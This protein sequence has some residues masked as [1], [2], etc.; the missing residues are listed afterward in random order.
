MIYR[1]HFAH[2]GVAAAFLAAPAFAQPPTPARLAAL[3]DSVAPAAVAAA[4]VPGVVVAVVRGDS[5]LLLRGYGLARL[6][7]SIPADPER[8]IYRLAS[9]AK[10]F[11]ATTVLQR[12]ALGKL[13]LERDIQEYVPNVP[14]PRTFDTP[15][16]LRHLL[17][18][19]G[20][21]DERATGYAARTRGDMRPLGEY[22]AAR[23]PDRGWAPGAVVG[24][25]NH[26]MALAGYVAEREAGDAFAALAAR[27]VFVPMGMR[28]TYY[29]E[30]PD[31]ALGDRLAPGYRCGP[32]GCDRAPVVWSHAYPV[33]LAFSTAH[34]MSRFMR[35]WLNDGALDGT[36]VL[37]PSVVSRG[38]TRQFAHDAR[39]PGMGFG[40]FEQQY[41]GHRVFAHSGG[42]PGTAT[43]LVLA[44]AERLGVFVATNA[45]EP[46]VT[47]MIVESLLDA[48]LTDRTPPP[49]VATGPVREYA[50]TYRLTRYAHHTVERFPGVFAFSVSARAEG[51]T[52]IMPA[53]T[54]ER[55]FV[56]VD[57]LLLREVTD[58]TMMAL[59]RD[60]RGAV[61]HLF[62]GLP[63]GGAELPG[64][65]ERAPWYE[66]TH[67]LNEYASALVGLPPL[68]LLAW[69]LVA[70]SRRLWRRRRGAEARRVPR[71]AIAAIVVAVAGCVLFLG[72]GLGFIAVGTRDLARSQGMA[73]GMTTADVALL[74]LAW[75][76]AAASLAVPAF[77]AISW[78]QRWWTLFGRLSYSALALLA[79]ATVHFLVWWQYIP[80]RW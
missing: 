60:G 38:M 5:V 42:V 30:P 12:V 22:L 19:T 18:H 70:I 73:F 43:T 37:D 80:G 13:D 39:V 61:S 1:A 4:H 53:G 75:V 45:G 35:A 24:Y 63:S 78:R 58:G 3:V 50:G 8:S 31:V 54:R 11:V 21:F 14:I 17:T 15:I 66:G 56:R 47:R 57:S 74:R 10:L 79:V 27:S 16:T 25:S 32:S 64:A 26:G 9:V 59:R 77:A 33:G 6:E 68:V 36:T 29:I 76:A 2:I 65:F 41:R 34:D 72:F 20:G 48:V 71:S 40:F 51:D 52:L 69:A 49:P 46:S 44:P 28:S 7:D 55:R 67:F 23:L 62:T